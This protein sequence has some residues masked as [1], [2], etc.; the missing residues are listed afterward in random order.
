MIDLTNVRESSFDLI[1]AGNYNVVLDT[2]QIKETKDGT[3]EYI[4]CKFVI[5]GGDHDDRILFHMFNIKN[6]NAQ[7][8]EIG[9]SQLKSFMKCAGAKDFNIKSVS[10]LEGMQALAVVKT[11]TDSYGEKNVISY[12]KPISALDKGPNQQRKEVPF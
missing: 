2:A 9:L 4:N 8:T 11:K 7:A 10:V 3:G 1:P 5:V 12:F 6:K